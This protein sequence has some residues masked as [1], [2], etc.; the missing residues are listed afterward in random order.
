MKLERRR[1][2]PEFKARVA[3]EAL[4]GV[5]TGESN[6]EWPQEIT[7]KEAL[8]IRPWIVQKKF[9]RGMFASSSSM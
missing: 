8:N 4:K 2:D 7:V 3:L 1:L 5:K 9:T 6:P